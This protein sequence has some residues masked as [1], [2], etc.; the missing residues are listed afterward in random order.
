MRIK[1]CVDKKTCAEV[2][3]CGYNDERAERMP[4]KKSQPKM[5]T[6]PLWSLLGL[7]LGV[8]DASRW[9]INTTSPSRVFDGIGGLSAGASSRLLFNYPEQERN[10][11]SHS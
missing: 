6:A 10:E 3:A 9:I 5:L 11:D 4:N 1:T 7:A 8:S 2:I